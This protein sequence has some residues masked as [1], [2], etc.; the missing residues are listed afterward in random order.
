MKV[1]T[2]VGI[3]LGLTGVG[4]FALGT[5]VMGRALDR[6]FAN[7]QMA[8]RVETSCRTHLARLTSSAGSA[9]ASLGTPAGG[10]RSMNFLPGGDIEIDFG[11]VKGDPRLALADA[12]AS[13]ATCPTRR[14]TEV[15]LGTS[16]S[17]QPS[18]QIRLVVRLSSVK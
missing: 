14:I 12:T 5:M 1:R 3:I 10:A 4:M 13:L 7:E 15:C 8:Q 11:E 2:A 6:N 17:R 18:S 9:P 16:C